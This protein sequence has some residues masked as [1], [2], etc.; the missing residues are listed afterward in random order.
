MF[1]MFFMIKYSSSLEEGT[2]R[3]SSADFL[4]MLMFG[5]R[6]AVQAQCRQSQSSCTRQPSFSVQLL[7]A[8]TAASL[9]AKH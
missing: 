1:H 8:R 7:S 3:S 6:R 5:T 4:W 2:F 9:L